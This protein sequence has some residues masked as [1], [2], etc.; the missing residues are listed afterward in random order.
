MREGEPNMKRTGLQRGIAIAH[1]FCLLYARWSA[2]M[3]SAV[4]TFPGVT[5]AQKTSAHNALNAVAA[6]CDALA[7]F[8]IVFET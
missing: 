3:H 5:E 1:Q 8:K 2:T 4:D 6:A 7:A